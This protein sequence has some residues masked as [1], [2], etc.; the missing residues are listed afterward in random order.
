MGHVHR[1]A[2]V[3]CEDGPPLDMAHSST[4]RADSP[5]IRTGNLA[6]IL[7]NVPVLSS[8][9]AGW[10]GITLEQFRCPPFETPE[11]SHPDHKI[12]IHTRIPKDLRVR[13]RLNGRLQ[14]ERVVA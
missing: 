9:G 2:A 7:P 3:A 13:R 11:Y 12:A 14:E 5:T 6:P 4:T 8:A 10:Q 1:L